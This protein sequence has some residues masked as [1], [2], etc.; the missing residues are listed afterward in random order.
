M[1]HPLRIALTLLCLSYASTPAWAQSETK[2][3]ASIELA[4]GALSL[5][6][7]EGWES[8]PPRSGMLEHEMKLPAP[9][10]A[11]IADGRLTIMAAGGSIQAN[12]SR[13]VGQFQGTE[14]GADRSGAKIEEAEADGMKVTLF[15]HSGTFMQSAG[16]PFGPKT[17]MSDYRM[18]AAIVET[19]VAGNYFIKLTGPQEVL[20]PNAEAFREMVLSIKKN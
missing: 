15:D 16:G 8:V 20:D 6:A 10:G 13:W 5:T 14:G 3:S 19:G 1:N 9:E 2:P 18:L 11:E 7:P 12:L 4:S 17:P